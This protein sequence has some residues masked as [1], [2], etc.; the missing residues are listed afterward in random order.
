[1]KIVI[2]TILK[3]TNLTTFTFCISSNLTLPPPSKSVFWKYCTEYI[4][5]PSYL[6]NG[7]TYPDSKVHGTNMGPIWGRQDP[8]GPHVGPMDLVIWVYL[9]QWHLYIKMPPTMSTK[10]LCN[11][12]GIV[13]KIQIQILYCIILKTAASPVLQKQYSILHH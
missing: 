4:M 9:Q 7:N 5:R 1:M 3:K 11:I 6:Y 10:A 2:L 12:S 13:F 8:G